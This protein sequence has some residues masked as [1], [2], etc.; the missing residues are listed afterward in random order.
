MVIIK[1]NISAGFHQSATD[2][3]D[4][5]PPVQQGGLFAAVPVIE[6]DQIRL[7]FPCLKETG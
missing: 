1:E 3:R 5:I 2:D 7:P 4:S 6:V